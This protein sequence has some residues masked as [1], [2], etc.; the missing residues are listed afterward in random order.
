LNENAETRRAQGE[1]ALSL[2]GSFPNVFQHEMRA[3]R[4]NEFLSTISPEQAEAASL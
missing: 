3:V 1:E 2:P 4:I